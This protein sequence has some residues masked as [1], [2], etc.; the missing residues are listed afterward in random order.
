MSPLWHDEIGVY[1]S[2]HRLCLVR[3]QRGVRP[4][5]IAE[6]EQ[7]LESA[8]AAGWSAPL[9]ALEAL[10]AQPA[11]QGAHLR[12]VLADHWARYTIVPW[13]AELSSTE[14]QLAHARQLLTSIYGEVVSDW[15]L[16]L[17]QT[18]PQTARVVCTI[19]VALLEGIRAACAKH[20]V[21]L[22]SLQPQLI[23][24]YEA[25]RHCLPPSN[26]WFVTVEQ[27]SLAAAR[28]GQHGWDRVHS[29]RIGSDWTRELKRLQTF[30]RLASNIPEEGQV[31]VDAPHAWREVAAGAAGASAAAG[32]LHWLEEEGGPMTTLQR[33]VR[34]RR[35]AA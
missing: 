3:M 35:L 29:V 27:G 32:G 8:Q 5:P 18:P 28:I 21:K 22:T 25:W 17:S 24:A 4:K 7:A 12:V 31:F 30:G 13:V 33:L 26:A 16:R 19:P 11:W 9:D 15:D 6:H 20:A 10:L 2:P 34:A 14:E 23:A 1:L